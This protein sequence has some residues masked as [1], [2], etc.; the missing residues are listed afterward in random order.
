R[1]MGSK[2]LSITNV[3]AGGDFALSNT[4]GTSVAGGGSCAITVTFTPTVHGDRTGTITITD[5][6]QN[7]PTNVVNLSGTGTDGAV[8]NFSPAALNFGDQKVGTTGATQKVTL[9]NIGNQT[10]TLSGFDV[11]GDFSQ[12]DNCPATLVPA[13]SCPVS[14]TFTPAVVGVRAGSV[15]ITDST[16]TS[17]ELVSLTGT[18]VSPHPELTVNPSGLSFLDQAVGTT[19]S[20]YRVT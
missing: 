12:T 8:L 14:V 3:V 19:S 13:A 15:V 5:D 1:N 9:S 18:G 4:C 20:Q 10:L 7:G 16:S 11:T 2:T 17:P 6:A